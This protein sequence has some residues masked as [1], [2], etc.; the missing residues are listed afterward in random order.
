MV[1]VVLIICANLWSQKSGMASD[2]DDIYIYV[3]LFEL[4]LDQV[5]RYYYLLNIYAFEIWL[6]DASSR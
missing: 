6:K 1:I 4:I 2:D 5:L 3:K